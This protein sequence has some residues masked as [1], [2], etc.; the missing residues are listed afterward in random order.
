VI[1]PVHPRTRARLK[2]LALD[3]PN[4]LQLCEPLPYLEFL[5]LMMNARVVLTDSGGIQE[6]TTCLGVPC[7]T[8]RHNTERP[9]TVSLGTNRIIGTRPEAILDA[10][11]A[12]LT[13]PMPSAIA[14][15]F[16]DGAAATR[17]V[18]VLAQ[19]LIPELTAV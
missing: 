3:V 1:F 11:R 7:L 8:L 2:S 18:E 14:P 5:S 15:P 19:A 16:W 13:N 6:E 4:R 12:T 9:V 10:V 17:I